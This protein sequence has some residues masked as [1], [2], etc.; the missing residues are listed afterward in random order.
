MYR[1]RVD[2]ALVSVVVHVESA[3]GLNA[4]GGEAGRAA[5]DRG[6][7]AR[8]ILRHC[9]THYL[10]NP[11]ANVPRSAQPWIVSLVRTIF[12]HPDPTPLAA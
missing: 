6:G 9:R 10:R 2:Q 12:D 7:A 1:R 11:L 8:R 3:R 4:A 5:Q